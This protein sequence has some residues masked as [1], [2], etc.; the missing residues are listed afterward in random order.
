MV[1]CMIGCFDVRQMKKRF[2]VRGSKIDTIPRIDPAFRPKL[3][4]IGMYA[5]PFP[6]YL[7][8]HGENLE[9]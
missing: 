2:F 5:Q 6:T 9:P 1:S 4:F 7:P 3:S 8:S